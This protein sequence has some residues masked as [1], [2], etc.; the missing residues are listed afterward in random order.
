[1][2]FL[3]DVNILVAWGWS[4]HVSHRR[5]TEWIASTHRD[6]DVCLLTSAIP[7]LGFVRVSV[8]RTAGGVS[9]AESAKVLS[10]ML[11]TLGD[12][13]RFLPDDQ[14]SRSG[15]PDWCRSAKRSTD[16]HLH[17]LAQRHGAQLATLDES[18][19]GAFLIPDSADQTPGEP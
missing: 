5:A 11:E 3:L 13:H 1:M 19:P 2:T 16:A 14:T 15:W 6:R 17:A 8:Q 12:R 4:D 18:I 9:I 10:G 7:Q